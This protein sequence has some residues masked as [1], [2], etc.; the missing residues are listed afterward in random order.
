MASSFTSEMVL[1]VVIIL[2]QRV[3]LK[4][5]Y[6]DLLM[7]NAIPVNNW[8][9][10]PPPETLPFSENSC[11]AKNCSAHLMDQ[12]TAYSELPQFSGHTPLREALFSES[13][14]RVRVDG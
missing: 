12:F 2:Q 9:S 13:T 8:I 14:L 4:M 1:K 6:R 5:H 10:S 3:A 7:N 11:C